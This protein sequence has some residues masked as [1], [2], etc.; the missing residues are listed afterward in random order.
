M[1]ISNFAYTRA[2]QGCVLAFVAAGALAYLYLLAAPYTAATLLE[3]RKVAEVLSLLPQGV[4][5]GGLMA[6]AGQAGAGA[7]GEA[8]GPAR[9]RSSASEGGV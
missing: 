3:S 2:L 1:Y 8:G 7:P 5:V 4:D 6:L 9:R